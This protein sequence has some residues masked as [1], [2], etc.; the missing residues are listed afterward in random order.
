MSHVPLPLRRVAAAGVILGLAAMALPAAAVAQG[1]PPDQT[2]VSAA[3]VP[4][5]LVE[6]RDVD[7]RLAQPEDRYALAGGCY[8]IEVPGSGY[9]TREDDALVLAPDASAAEPFHFQPLRLGEYLIA[10][11]EGRDTAYEEAWWDV[12][13]YVSAPADPT[14]ALAS[15]GVALA[16]E[17]S[18]A[19]EWSV[20]AAGDDPDRTVDTAAGATAS[21]VVSRASG[22]GHLAAADGTLTTSDTASEVVF[23]HVTDDDPFDDDPNGAAC[24]TWPEIETNVEGTP[25]G[26]RANPAAP[27]RGFFEAHVHGMAFEFLGGEL[28]CGRPWHPYGVEYALGDCSEE[29]NHLNGVLEVGLAGQ[30]PSDPVMAY[31]PVGWPTF[32][33]WPKHDT[34]THEQFYWR[35]VERA[36]LGGLRLVTNLLVDNTAL[37]QAYPVKRNS[38]NEMDGVRLQAERMYQLQD[39]VDAQSG[40]PGEGWLRIVTSPSEARRTI[41][42]GR[43]AVVLGIEVSELFDCREV[44]DVPQC[45][46]AEIDERLNEVLAMGVRQMELVNKFDNAL[47]GVTGD[48]GETGMVVN[49]GNRWVTGHYWDMQTCADEAHD[50]GIEGD[51]HDKHQRNV[52]DDRPQGGPEEID[53][54]AGTVLGLFGPT[55]GYVAPAYPAGPHCNARGL[56]D[57]GRHLIERMT[58]TGVIFDPDHMS[59]LAQRE[60]LDHIEDTVIPTRERAAAAADRPSPRPGIISSHSW[61]NDVTYQRI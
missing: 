11:N 17:P 60:A 42:A 29:N 6:D 53:V 15:S 10:A 19:G 1:Q 12:R 36:Y 54:L 56:S 28:R 44:L 24:A 22:D 21:Y 7:D 8:A 2:V 9:V 48:G 18:P 5:A 26:V 55:K 39:Y 57:L 4:F 25:T 61:G 52:S 40:G 50:H 30:D 37:C 13:S 43:M 51:E 27:V 38:C 41:N 59:A 45:T 33:Y 32:S 35:W 16:G 46:E 14:A 47:S 49:T 3:K 20:V 31:D 58:E 34:L 23:H